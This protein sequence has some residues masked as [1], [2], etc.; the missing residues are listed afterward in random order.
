MTATID[1]HLDE[2]WRRTLRARDRRVTE[3]LCRPLMN[4]YGYAR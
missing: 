3:V 4:R 2:E 1:L